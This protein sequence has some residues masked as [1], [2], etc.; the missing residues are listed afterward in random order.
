M[1]LAFLNDPVIIYNVLIGC[2]C[3][4]TSSL[5]K[6]LKVLNVQFFIDIFWCDWCKLN[7]K[8]FKTHCSLNI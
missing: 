1:C 3:V 5:Y 2:H 6:K 4:I 7:N 8:P